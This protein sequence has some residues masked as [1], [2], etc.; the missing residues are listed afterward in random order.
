MKIKVGDTQQAEAA[1][2][3]EEGSPQR[4]AVKAKGGVSKETRDQ[5]SHSDPKPKPRAQKLPSIRYTNPPMAART[6][7]S[8][9]MYSRPN[10]RCP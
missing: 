4:E 3:G 10:S 1:D 7:F 8:S 6:V 9:K 5:L 2:Q